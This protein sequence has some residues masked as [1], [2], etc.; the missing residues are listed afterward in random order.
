MSYWQECLQICDEYSLFSHSPLASPP[1]DRARLTG[2]QKKLFSDVKAYIPLGDQWLRYAP[3]S[4]GLAGAVAASAAVAA[5]AAA[6]TE[7]VVAAAAAVAAARSP[8]TPKLPGAAAVGAGA[9]QA[10]STEEESPPQG[11]Q[12][13]SPSPAAAAAHSTS[14]LAPLLPKEAEAEAAAVVRDHH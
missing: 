2:A 9:V 4:A 12:H 13:L 3:Q 11:Q 5:A 8:D 7:A 1:V 14:V 10:A 6:A